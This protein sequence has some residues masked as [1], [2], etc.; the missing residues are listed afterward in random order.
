MLVMDITKL[1]CTVL[2]FSGCVLWTKICL[3]DG[4]LLVILYVAIFLCWN[5]VMLQCNFPCDDL[6]LLQKMLWRIVDLLPD[7]RQL[8]FVLYKLVLF[9]SDQVE[10]DV[11]VLLQG[12]N[13]MSVCW[14]LLFGSSGFP[15]TG[16]LLPCYALKYF[17]I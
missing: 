6:V 10:C 15:L 5:L 4:Y 12:I 16:S 17:I 8:Y 3:C 14:P 7:C 9:Q 2:N 13:L 1:S 11:L